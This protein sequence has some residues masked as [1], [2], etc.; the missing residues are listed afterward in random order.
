MNLKL[1]LIQHELLDLSQRDVR[2][3]FGVIQA[4]IRVFFFF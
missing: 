2:T 4:T 3:R 1:L